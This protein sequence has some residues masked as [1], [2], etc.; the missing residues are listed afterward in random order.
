MIQIKNQWING[1]K[2]VCLSYAESEKNNKNYLIVLLDTKENNKI[3]IEVQ[4]E[5][6]FT[7]VL[8]QV[9]NQMQND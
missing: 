8:Q 9:K 5:N 6:E 1:N 7:A 4:N 3:F 2:I